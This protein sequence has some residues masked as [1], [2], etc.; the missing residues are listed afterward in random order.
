MRHEK[1]GEDEGDVAAS[2]GGLDDVVTASS[3]E[4]GALVDM[5]NE[6]DSRREMMS[7]PRSNALT[8]PPMGL[9]VAVLPAA[10]TIFRHVICPPTT[11]S[12]SLPLPL[13]PPT[14]KLVL[15]V[16]DSDSG[17]DDQSMHG[18]KRTAVEVLADEAAR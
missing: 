16:G 3:S 5:M 6:I 4:E 1:L 2:G 11:S 12:S 10:E 15:G 18:S 13:Q 8:G 7:M 14:T 17:S 9:M